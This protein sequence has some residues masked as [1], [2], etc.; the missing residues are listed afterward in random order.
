MSM[1]NKFNKA[2]FD[3]G[4]VIRWAG[5]LLLVASVASGQEVPSDSQLPDRTQR[6][7][8]SYD[9]GAQAFEEGRFSAALNRFSEAY[10][11]SSRA[12]LL[13]NLGASHDR[14]GRRADA[15][16][17]Y[18]AYLEALPEASNRAYTEARVEILQREVEEQAA[19][20]EAVRL[21]E[22][23]RMAQEVVVPVVPDEEPSGSS[24]I[25]AIMML[26]AA[27]VAGAA[28]VVT[29]VMALGQRG[30][31]DE[32]CPTT[33]CADSAQGDIDRL[34]RLSITTDVLLGV[35]VI[36]A[37]TGVVLFIVG[38]DD[39]DDASVACSFASCT[40]TVPF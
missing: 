3:R 16:S 13:Y 23:S 40:A 7:R 35:A 27:G 22:E 26:G 38:G 9:A 32:S 19:A 5:A 24:N 29:G 20:D 17:N 6:A 14:L 39:D 31:L 21:A 37:V 30:D 36:A 12:E 2:G 25:P 33:I 18:T 34:R 28:A 1:M 8:A 11:L 10:E 15:I 4:A